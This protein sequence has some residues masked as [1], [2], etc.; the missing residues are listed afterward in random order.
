M[1]D[2]FNRFKTLRRPS[3]L[4]RAARFGLAEYNRDRD[5][6]KLM[7][8]AVTPSP[9]VAVDELLQEEERLE[10]TRKT[11]DA[12][13]SIAYHIEVLVALMCEMR[14]LPQGPREV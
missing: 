7:K 8:S 12:S 13:Y 3:L 11:G 14:L 5:L 6:K 4:V 2:T 9:E 1:T 10:I